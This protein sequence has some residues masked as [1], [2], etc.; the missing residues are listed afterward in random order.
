[1]GIS[2]PA[3]AESSIGGP[4]DTALQTS[5][6]M[7]RRAWGDGRRGVIER[8]NGMQGRVD[9]DLVLYFELAAA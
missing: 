6:R 4:R 5:H 7:R 2:E 8:D 9:V 1:M 3:I